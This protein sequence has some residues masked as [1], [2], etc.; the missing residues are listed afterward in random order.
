MVSYAK[1][2]PSRFRLLLKADH[3]C[4]FPAKM[5]PRLAYWFLHEMARHSEWASKDRISFHDPM[6]GSG[7]SA[8]VARV[9]GLS[10]TASDLTFPAVII[11]KAKL[12]RLTS[13]HLTEMTVF[14][15]SLKASNSSMPMTLWKNWEIWYQSRVLRALE[16][17]RNAIFELKEEPFFPHLLTCLFQTAWDVSSAD[18]GVIVPTRSRF[19]RKA[20]TLT[21]RQVLENFLMRVNRILGAQEAL[22]EFGV[23]LTKPRIVQGDALDTRAWPRNPV[24]MILTSPPY[25]CGIDYERSFRLQ[26]RLCQDFVR[27]STSKSSMIGRREYLS[28]QCDEFPK[29][30]RNFQ[31]LKQLCVSGDRRPRML[32]QYLED[33]K[34]FLRMCSQHLGERGRLCLLLGN[35]Q[36][37]KR[38]IPLAR[39]II[40]LAASEDLY[41]QATPRC[42][43]IHSR[44]QN[45][46]PRSATGLIGKEY[47][48]V[49][50]R[51]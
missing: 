25:G 28:V 35:P 33:M 40:E 41:L 10:V 8:L 34:R 7:T 31:W 43:R 46:T 3:I 19:S 37:A 5:T 1:T 17:L 2:F 32:L 21:S 6:C 47:L 42:D 13:H 29:T 27:K 22:K 26:M 51:V 12:W 36:I 9:V 14:S 44:I 38:P 24:D 39:A 15:R 49:F 16:E 18:K 45:F 23:A 30:M 11:T 50:H 48:L 4:R 20:P